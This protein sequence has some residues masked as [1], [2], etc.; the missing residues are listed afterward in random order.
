MDQV[1]AGVILL[2]AVVSCVV[3]VTLDT[4]SKPEPK[5]RPSYSQQIDPA[6]QQQIEE[7]EKIYAEQIK[8]AQKEY[9]AQLEKAAKAAAEEESP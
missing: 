1:K 3:K 9:Q 8:Q 6:V 5:P 7:K 4:I 2:C